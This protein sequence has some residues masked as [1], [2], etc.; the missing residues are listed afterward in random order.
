[1]MDEDELKSVSSYTRKLP[2]QVDTHDFVY[3]VEVSKTVIAIGGKRQICE[4]IAYSSK[5]LYSLVSCR[6]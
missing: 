4:K 5:R 6:H 3:R 2:V 1:M